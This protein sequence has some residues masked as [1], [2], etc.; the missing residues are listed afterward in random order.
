M[1]YRILS[2]CSGL[3]GIDLGIEL[4]APGSR[5]VG[6]VE[7]EAFPASVILAR[8]EDE[9]LERAPVWCGD[10]RDLD[11]RPLRGHVDLITAGYPCQPF[12]VAG[13]RLGEADPRHLWP[14]VARIIGE[15]GPR[16]VF[17]ENV[18][19][20]LRLGF[21]AV[22]G[23]LADLGFDAEWTIVGADDVGAPHRRKRLFV[24]GYAQRSRT[25]THAEGCGSREAVGESD[26][27]LA[28]SD[29]ADESDQREGENGSRD[30]RPESRWPQSG[31]RGSSE[32]MADARRGREQGLQSGRGSGA[33]GIEEAAPS[34]D[35]RDMGDPARHERGPQQRADGQRIGEAGDAQELAH[36][37]RGGREGVRGRRILDGQRAA[38]RD[39]A[40]GRDGSSMADAQ[41]S[42]RSSE[43]K[44]RGAE[45]AGLRSDGEA[46]A[47]TD[48]SRLE[49]HGHTECA[50]TGEGEGEAARPG[51]YGGRQVGDSADDHR[52]TGER[53]AEA[54][55][56][57][58][59]ERGQRSAGAEPRP[60]WPPGSDPALWEGIEAASQP[61]IRGVANGATRGLERSRLAAL[62]NGVVPLAVAHAFRTLAAR[63]GC[64]W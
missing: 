47:D 19:A 43:R 36:S 2:L 57:P 7:R 42:G 13:K 5:A 3:G 6:Y 10:L 56:G 54:G 40:D 22:L 34:D 60:L 18:N 53:E 28:D 41:G 59:G 49:R 61:A 11:A 21:D 48:S 35:G 55:T 50:S 24:L 8:M 15:V 62:G 37:D 39:D 51:L 27:E 46:M 4:A 16:L 12:S 26:G 31:D 45:I 58:D 64:S 25:V 33:G 38:L 52:G 14:E 9:S 32:A 23:D 30:I 20:H 1:A 29:G 44:R 63:A 17:L